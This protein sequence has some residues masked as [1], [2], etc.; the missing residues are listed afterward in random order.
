MV[1]WISGTRLFRYLYAI[2][3]KKCIMLNFMVWNVNEISR[4]ELLPN[5]D[6]LSL[7]SWMKVKLKFK[8]SENL[9][10]LQNTSIYQM[11]PA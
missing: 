10:G 7:I 2:V 5:I 8:L 11:M 1:T 4:P 3:Q 6:K 9:Y